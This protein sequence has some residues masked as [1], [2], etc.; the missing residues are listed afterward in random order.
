MKANELMIGDWVSIKG[1]PCKVSYL[2]PFDIGDTRLSVISN[3][4]DGNTYLDEIEPIPLTTEILEA[5]GWTLLANFGGEDY[6][7]EDG[8]FRL[9]YNKGQYRIIIHG[10][11]IKI[12]YVHELQRVLRCC[13][14]N[15][16]ADNFKI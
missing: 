5:N 10:I 3:G 7:S 2:A 12:T 16:I 1:H 6:W 13:G 9:P 15:E 11:V 4:Y 8:E 14:L